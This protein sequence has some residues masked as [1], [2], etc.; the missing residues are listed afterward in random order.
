MWHLPGIYGST[1]YVWPILCSLTHTDPHTQPRLRTCGHHFCGP[2][3]RAF[4]STALEAKLRSI[5]LLFSASTH[6]YDA[7]TAPTSEEHLQNTVLGLQIFGRDPH[8]I[9]CYMCPICK[10]S[11][12]SPPLDPITLKDVLC[13]I[14]NALDKRTDLLPGPGD[15]VDES[16]VR[17]KGYFVGLFL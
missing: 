8:T 9:F 2:C 1:L 15:L 16:L 12:Q 10:A 6:D 3:L 11:V 17:G 4:F 13:D 7:Y 14:R 5:R